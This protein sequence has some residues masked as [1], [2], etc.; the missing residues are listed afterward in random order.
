MNSSVTQRKEEKKI[1]RTTTLSAVKYNTEHEE[2]IK[3]R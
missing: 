2:K 1:K 3:V